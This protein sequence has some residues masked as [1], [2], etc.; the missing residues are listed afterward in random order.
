MDHEIRLAAFEWLK[1]QTLVHGYVLDWN[2]LI[3]GFSFKGNKVSLVQMPGIWTPNIMKLPISI[4]TT[5]GSQYNDS[6]GDTYIKYSFRGK[7][8]KHR[9]NLLLNEVMNSDVPIPLIYF[10]GISKGKYL[11]TWPVYIVNSD[12]DKLMYTVAVDDFNYISNT[13]IDLLQEK[14]ENYARREYYT[15]LVKTRAFQ[16]RFRQRVLEAYRNQCAICQLKHAELLDAAH[17]IPDSKEG[18]EPIVSN[19]LSLCKIHHAAFDKHILG[20]TPDYTIKLRED[21]LREIDGP[22][23]KYGLQALENNKIILPSHMNDRPDR[24]RLERRY[25]EFLDAS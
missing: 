10:F 7:N 19:G 21:I 17:I 22:M 15:T 6:F 25:L 23:L 16:G 4:R 1:T 13:G 12:P 11:A 14:A 9:D 18:G 5:P 2:L 24:D 8:P 3:K 20:I